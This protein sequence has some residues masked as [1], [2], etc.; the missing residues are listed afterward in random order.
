MMYGIKVPSWDVSLKLMLHIN[1]I[2][3]NHIRNIDGEKVYNQG[4]ARY[5]EYEGRSNSSDYCN[6]EMHFRSDIASSL[7]IDLDNVEILFV[8]QLNSDGVV[9]NFRFIPSLPFLAQGT[10]WVQNVTV[11]LSELVS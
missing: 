9:I 1:I 6:F 11:V 10:E 2:D 8:R 3:I 4:G 5:C 7:A